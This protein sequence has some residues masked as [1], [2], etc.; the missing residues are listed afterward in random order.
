MDNIH[1][2]SVPSGPAA[3]RGLPRT[4][5]QDPTSLMELMAE[6]QRVEGE[7]S[8]L[9]SVLDTVCIGLC[10]CEDSNIDGC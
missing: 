4:A 5:D 7:L 6:K 9:S 3:G 10:R 2:P 8:E 1:M